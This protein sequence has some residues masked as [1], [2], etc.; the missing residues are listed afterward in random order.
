MAGH[1]VGD[2][3]NIAIVGH[4]GCG[5]TS[6][7]EAILNKAGVTN[8]LGRVD[9]GS[10]SLDF[11]D[12]SKERKQSIDSRVFYVE[13]NETLL[14]LIDTPGV[15]DYCG[16]AI[17]SLAG[18]ETAV[19]VVSAASGVEVN[20]RRMFSAAGDFGLARSRGHRLEQLRLRADH[21]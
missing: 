6:L 17:A 3:R 8:R 20:T 10:S 9:D 1:Q 21:R 5:K 18:V 2:I 14:N 12:E 15:P 7:G 11:D 4:A 16:T 19:V 13:H